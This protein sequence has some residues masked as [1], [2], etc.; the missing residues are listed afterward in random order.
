MLIRW[1]AAAIIGGWILMALVRVGLAD[2]PK[3]AA[4]WGIFP[5]GLIARKVVQKELSLRGEQV[6]KLTALMREFDVTVLEQWPEAQ[7][8]SPDQPAL[9]EKERI[10][11]IGVANTERAERLKRLIPR[12]SSRFA[13]ILDQPQIE[14]LQQILWQTEGVRAYRDP[15]VAKAIGL[16]RAQQTKLAAVWTMY[17]ERL[18]RLF[19]SDAAQTGS[20][21]VQRTV[22]KIGQ[23]FKERDSMMAA[24]AT[25]EQQARFERLKGRPFDL[26]QLRASHPGDTQ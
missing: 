20:P 21:E 14:R 13:K 23:L 25:P 15:G 26:K 5:N 3:C 19:Y 7:V 4:E 18:D 8:A 2:E 6:E 16:S 17:E 10:K 22:A 9:S 11:R 24:V 1:F 12:F